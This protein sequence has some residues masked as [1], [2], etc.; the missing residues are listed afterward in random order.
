MSKRSR[1]Q[2]EEISSG[3][4]PE[5]LSINK[6]NNGDALKHINYI[7]SHKIIVVLKTILLIIFRGC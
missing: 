2:L 6:N 4:I 7:Q 1:R 3:Q 5:N